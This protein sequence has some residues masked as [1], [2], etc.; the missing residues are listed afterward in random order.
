MRGDFVTGHRIGGR[1]DAGE[2]QQYEERASRKAGA[3]HEPQN[4]LEPGVF[5]PRSTHPSAGRQCERSSSGTLPPCS[6]SFRMTSLWSQM[7]IDAESFV[8][9]V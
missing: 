6:D 3:D 8:S 5:G 1:T 7:F 2:P 4:T 9:P